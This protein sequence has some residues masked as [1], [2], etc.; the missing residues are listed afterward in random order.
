M[1]KTLRYVPVLVGLI[2]I[3]SAGGL[4]AQGYDNNYERRAQEAIAG[5]VRLNGL[6]GLTPNAP[7]AWPEISAHQSG[8]TPTRPLLG[9]GWNRQESP[10]RLETLIMVNQGLQR[11]ADLS[12]LTGLRRLEIYGNSL[13][14]LNLEGDAAL[15]ILMATKNQLGSLN[16]QG[17]PR[18][19]ILAASGN[20][21]TKLD[22][23]ANRDLGELYLSM[24]QLESLDLSRN[25]SLSALE[26][27]NNGLKSLDLSACPQLGRLLV[28]HN[29]LTGLDLS[30]NP[31]LVELGAGNN[32]LGEL[33]LGS[34]PQLTELAVSRNQLGILDLTNLIQL[35]DL[36]VERNRLKVL[37]LSSNPALK[38]LEAQGNP[39]EKIMVGTNEF[40]AL[41]V[42]NLDGCR[43]PLSQ[44]APLVGRAQ[45]RARF[46]SQEPVLFESARLPAG[47]AL[48]LSA[49]AVIDGA[50]TEFSVQTDKKRR[51]KP[52]D[53]RVVE[54]RVIFLVPGRYRVLM[55]NE[56]VFSS[57]INQPTGRVR[58]FKVKATTGLIEVLPAET[59]ESPSF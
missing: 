40:P 47:Q 41:E 38:T 23:S 57:E 59:G 43:L 17:S 31:D 36:S 6:R 5:L 13:R 45:K 18:L 39:L 3:M 55:T 49:E 52:A 37:D 21:L 58:T 42:L 11:A 28:S 35:R 34:N 30:A 7:G 24:N 4:A 53:Y 44:L 56:R 9:V 10:A 20:Q 27:M 19:R 15:Q 50:A 48:D 51:V 1:R 2:L 16:L 26:L 46:G 25:T 12:G 29:R 54:G 22:L 14:A 33:D 32:S 8:V